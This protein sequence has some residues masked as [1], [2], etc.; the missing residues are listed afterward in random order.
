MSGILARE[1]RG[2]ARVLFT[3]PAAASFRRDKPVAG[4]SDGKVVYRHTGSGTKEWDAMVA[5][6]AKGAKR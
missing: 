6:L 2:E 3:A 1:T 4:A 5:F